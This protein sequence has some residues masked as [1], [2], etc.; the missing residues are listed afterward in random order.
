VPNNLN[1]YES[2][3][4]ASVGHGLYH[5]TTSHAGVDYEY[6]GDTYLARAISG[7]NTY[8]LYYDA[9]GR[10]VKRVLTVSGVDTVRYYLFD[11]EHWITEYDGNGVFSSNGLYG[12]E[13]DE[14]IARGRGGTRPPQWLF[15]D[16]NGNTSVVLNSAGGVQESYRYDAFGTPSFFGANGAALPGGSAIDNRFLFTGREWN[17]R[18][19]FYEYRARAYHP[20]LGRFM[21]ED[22]ILFDA[23]RTGMIRV[24]AEK[25]ALRADEREYN[26]Y[27]YC[28]IGELGSVC[29]S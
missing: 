11:G 19:G 24:S 29:K 12:L 1:Q 25:D 22:P 26:L 16:R 2:V 10:C 5:E 6:V 21:S 8:T 7:A 27:R 20:G 17:Q 28:G 9:L 23:R 14:I 4:G 18:F 3:G 15:P 13:I